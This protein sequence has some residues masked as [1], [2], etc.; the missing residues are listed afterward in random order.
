MPCTR[1]YHRALAIEQKSCRLRASPSRHVREA[2][3]QKTS[4]PLSNPR[5]SPSDRWSARGSA[6]RS[7]GALR[8]RVPGSR[9]F[10][11]S[12]KSSSRPEASRRRLRSKKAPGGEGRSL[13]RAFTAAPLTRQWQREAMTRASWPAMR[14]EVK[15]SARIPRSIRSCTRPASR[16]A[17][18]KSGSP[19]VQVSS[20]SLPRIAR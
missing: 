2:S 18:T 5:H 8:S 19:R 11:P 20:F 16:R 14:G 13:R 7:Q 6:R 9:P 15:D 12:E 4:Q 1:D 3:S 17:P 10:P